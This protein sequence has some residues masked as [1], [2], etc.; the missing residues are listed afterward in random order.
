MKQFCSDESCKEHTMTT[1]FPSV[2]ATQLHR[3]QQSGQSPVLIDVRSTA[4]YRAGHIPGAQ[5]IP[6]DELSPAVLQQ[7]LGRAGPG[8]DETLY[9]TCQA[10]P[11]AARAAQLLR[12]SGLRNVALVEG[13]TQRWQQA[14]LPLNRCGNAISLERQVQ[15]TLG[16]LLVL[17]VFLGYGVHELFFASAAF[18]GAG[19][20]YAG[21][22]RWCGLSQLLA[23][24][25][26]NRTVN[27][28]E[29]AS[30]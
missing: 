1:G 19:L 10:G 13:G 29:Q 11:R 14:G 25:P 6:V 28:P 2:T 24:M 20:I 9:L 23:R 26:W 7:R 4:E 18:I 15:I 17:K 21:I 16:G 12:Q 30:S 27:C 22:T 8:S 5:L 3:W